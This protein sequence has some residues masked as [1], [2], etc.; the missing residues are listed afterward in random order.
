MHVHVRVR[1]RANVCKDCVHLILA[2]GV[3][4][5]QPRLLT[6]HVLITDTIWRSLFRNGSAIV[7]VSDCISRG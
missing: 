2:R 6:E 1:V 5:P 7:V 3:S 4:R